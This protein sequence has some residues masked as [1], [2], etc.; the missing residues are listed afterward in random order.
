[1][2]DLT[3]ARWHKSTRSGSNGGDCVEVADNLPGI[4]AVRDSKDPDGPALVFP[5]DTWRAFVDS[6]KHR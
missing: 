3:G 1:M 2:A 4:V 6:L 5:R